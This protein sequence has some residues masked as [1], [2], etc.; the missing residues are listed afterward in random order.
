MDP[1]TIVGAQEKR[2]SLT[3]LGI[4]SD[5]LSAQSVMWSVTVSTKLN[6]LMRTCYVLFNDNVIFCRLYHGVSLSANKFS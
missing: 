3:H 6:Q 2:K 5:S 1:R 4:E